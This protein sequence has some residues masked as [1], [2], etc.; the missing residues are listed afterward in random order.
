MKAVARIAIT[1]GAVATV[2][3]G[4]CGGAWWYWDQMRMYQNPERVFCRHEAELREYVARLQA[5]QVPAAV[6]REPNEYCMPQFLT[7]RGATR[8]FW[9]E[10]RAVIVFFVGPV[11]AVPQLEYSP[12]AFGPEEVERERHAR[13]HFRWVPLAPDWAACYWDD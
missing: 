4:C 7:N 2:F 11:D 8:A 12:E 9:R 5:G 3:G 13:R 1:A 6:G 10:G